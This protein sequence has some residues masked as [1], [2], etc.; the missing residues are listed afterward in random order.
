MQAI[1]TALVIVI[2]AV[3]AILYLP[4]P[5]SWIVGLVLLLVAVWVALGQ[6]RSTGP[7]G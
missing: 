2:I 3:V 6:P 5:F 4:S 1:V 7:R